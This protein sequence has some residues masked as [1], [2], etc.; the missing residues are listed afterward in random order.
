MSN[1]INA[2]N[3]SISGVAGLKYSADTSGVLVLQTNG[4]TALTIDTS[5]NVGI[6]VTPS[7]WSGY[8]VNQISNGAVWASNNS[9]VHLSGNTYFDGTNYKYIS[10]DY[11]QDYYQY[12]GTHVWRYAASGTAGTN[13]TFTERMRIDSSGNVGIGT[14][15][16][17]NYGAGYK[18]LAL[19]GTSSGILELQASGTA[20][21]I[22]VADSSNLQIQALGARPVSFFTNGNERMRI[23]SSGNVGIGTSSAGY[24]LDVQAPT[25][26]VGV[27]STTGT[28]FA[29]FQ[30]NNTGGSFQLGIDNSGGSNFGSGVAYARCLW[31]DSASAPTI[32]YTNS[33]ERMRID[34]SGNLQ[35]TSGGISFNAGASAV[36]NDYE[37][38]TYT[39]TV[40]NTSGAITS[41][42]AG[43]YVKT[44]RMVNV[45]VNI[46][47]SSATTG[48]LTFTL[49]FTS[50]SLSNYNACLTGRENAVVGFM[51]QGYV[52]TNSSTVITWTYNNGVTAVTGYNLLLTLTYMTN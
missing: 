37:V 23:D 6:G 19:N 14:S 39:P 20:Q 35:I 36:L 44:G 42:A 4:T 31:N 50:T 1:I 33:T 48:T 49:P 46:S 43:F 9:L 34:S 25:G 52:G 21:A 51:V 30:V 26:A 22:L 12:Q 38:G 10:T 32:F 2:D 29:K 28:T 3:G 13:V 45:S 40:A 47:I 5:Q 41:S 15:S 18:T 24:R 7:T 11:A 27:T 16:P 17:T 8:T